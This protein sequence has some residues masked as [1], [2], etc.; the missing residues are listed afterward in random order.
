MKRPFL[1][2]DPARLVMGMIFGVVGFALAGSFTLGAKLPTPL[3][4]GALYTLCLWGLWNVRTT[5]AWLSRLMIVIYTAPFTQA[6]PLLFRDRA[7]WWLPSSFHFVTIMLDRDVSRTMVNVGLMGLTVLLAGL[8]LAGALPIRWSSRMPRSPRSPRH[9]RFWSFGVLLAWSFV[10][11]WLNASPETLLSA[12][13]ITSDGIAQQN[14]LNSAYLLSYIL[15][16]LLMVD[17]ENIT[18]PPTKRLRRWILYLSVLFIVFYFQLLR[19]NR[20]SV[21]LLFGLAGLYLTEPAFCATARKKDKV[22][23]WVVCGITLILLM[24]PFVMIQRFR[25]IRSYQNSNTPERLQLIKQGVSRVFSKFKNTSDNPDSSLPNAEV[26]QFYEAT[27]HFYPEQTWGAC[28]LT[29]LSM[30]NQYQNGAL[31][32]EWG[33][34]YWQYA[35]SLPPGILTRRLGME[36]PMERNRNPAWWFKDISAGGA[37]IVTVP[38]VNFRAWGVAILLLIYGVFIGWTD[39]CSRGRWAGRF[40]YG[41]FCLVCFHWFWYGDMFMIRGAMAYGLVL[42]SYAIAQRSRWITRPSDAPR[43]TAS[44]SE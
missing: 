18:H 2:E 30:A 38:F 5:Q 36:R 27:K 15:L 26:V 35:L 43:E 32:M 39:Q 34:T 20:E 6:W 33:R 9:F 37:H 21:G 31:P 8:Y 14:N 24:V 3:A 10:F 1:V 40:W 42:V 44:S 11:S 4:L 12:K 25:E 22:R 28:L 17:T 16:I 29:N 41:A 23:R 7:I 13:T 19:G